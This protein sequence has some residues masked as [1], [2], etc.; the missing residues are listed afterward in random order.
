[1]DAN[2]TRPMVQPHNP[3]SLAVRSCVATK[4][5]VEVTNQGS[6]TP[7]RIKKV[8]NYIKMPY[9]EADTARC[10]ASILDMCSRIA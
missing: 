2:L 10:G 9:A 6:E 4:G 5:W 3:L 1:M 8:L 7:Y